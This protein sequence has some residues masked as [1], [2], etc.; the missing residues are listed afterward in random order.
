MILIYAICVL[1]SPI[2]YSISPKVFGNVSLTWFAFY[3]LLLSFLLTRFTVHKR[4]YLNIWILAVFLFFVIVL[5]SLSWSEFYSVYD[6]ETVKRIIGKYFVPFVV[7]VIGM[8]LFDSLKT[9]KQFLYHVLMS[10]FILAGFAIVQVVFGYTTMFRPE[11]VPDPYRATATFINPNGLAIFLVL[12]VPH[13]IFA[14]RNG[15]VSRPIG[16][17]LVM[18]VSAAIVATASRKGL[19]TLFLAMLTYLWMIKDYKTLSKI[20][21]LGVLVGVAVLSHEAISERF[22]ARKIEMQLVGRTAMAKAGLDMFAKSPVYGIGYQGYYESFGKY[23]PFSDKQKY[24]AHNIYITVLANYGL[25]GFAVLLTIFLYPVFKSLKTFRFSRDPTLNEL[26]V[27]Y[28]TSSIPFMIN[29]YFAGGL[30]DSWP[31]M[32]LYY[33]NTAI[34][35]SIRRA[36]SNE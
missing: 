20:V 28:L 31:H 4:L 17:G 8:N 27:M 1:Y 13:I 22:E 21:A 19:F 5:S 9:Y 15:V 34:F 36:H 14:F 6:L 2:I 3:L 12:C 10:V 7:A 11:N 32:M 33:T 18:C 16:W 29:G 24:D 23:F 35:L 25:I 26:S 30:L